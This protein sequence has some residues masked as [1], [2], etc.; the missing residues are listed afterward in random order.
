MGKPVNP[1]DEGTVDCSR[2]TPEQARYAGSRG[3]QGT[4]QRGGD[5]SIAPWLNP[6]G[7]SLPAP[8]VQGT[9][10]HSFPRRAA[11]LHSTQ[12]AWQSPLLGARPV[13]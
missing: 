10:C 3:K 7:L 5:S 11:L 9:L 8:H 2:H 6:A 1:A 4:W 12:L 13:K